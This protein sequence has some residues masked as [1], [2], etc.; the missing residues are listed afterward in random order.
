MNERYQSEFEVRAC[1]VNKN[2]G[3]NNHD[4]ETIFIFGISAKT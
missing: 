4:L 3:D 1:G 2:S